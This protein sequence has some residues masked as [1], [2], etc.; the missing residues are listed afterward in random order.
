MVEGQEVEWD[1]VRIGELAEQTGVSA[2]AVRF[3]ERV[4]LLAAPPRTSGG[5]RDYGRDAISRLGFIKSAQ[6]IG[7]TL[8]EIREL[9]RWRDRGEDICEPV[10]EIVHRRLEDLTERIRVMEHT[11]AE[12]RKALRLARTCQPGRGGVCHII[13]RVVPRS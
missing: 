13:E 11:R 2:K 3:Y 5:Y 12:L 8:G 6:A 7:L 1:R 4:G 9:Q 10:V